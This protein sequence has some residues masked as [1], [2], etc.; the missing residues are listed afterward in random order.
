MVKFHGCFST[1]KDCMS[2]YGSR[3]WKPF[4][5]LRGGGTQWDRGAFVVV[6][7]YLCLNKIYPF[8][9]EDFN[10]QNHGQKSHLDSQFSAEAR[11][12]ERLPIWQSDL[13]YKSAFI[14]LHKNRKSAQM[15]NLFVQLKKK[16]DPSHTSPRD[17]AQIINV[18][19][20]SQI[21]HEEKKK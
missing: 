7:L 16:L 20:R 14:C 10:A 8:K 11:D 15:N 6:Y 9:T 1:Q 18:A 2:L 19:I 21:S 17:Q 12:V 4:R 13:L 5:N 3:A